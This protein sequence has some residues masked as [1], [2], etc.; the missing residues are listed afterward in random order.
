M[1]IVGGQWMASQKTRRRVSIAPWDSRGSFLF[2]ISDADAGTVVTAEI[3]LTEAMELR[4]W[5]A[6]EARRRVAEGRKP[7]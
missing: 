1:S 6:G 3:T 2:K 5:I 4:E 7:Q